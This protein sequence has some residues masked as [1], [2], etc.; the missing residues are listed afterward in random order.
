MVYIVLVFVF[1]IFSP[2]L[3]IDTSYPLA[4]SPLWHESRHLWRVRTKTV[5]LSR[6]AAPNT[7]A[8][9]RGRQKCLEDTNNYPFLYT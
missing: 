4:G 5:F 6:P 7:H 3:A 8:T 2:S 1:G 9:L